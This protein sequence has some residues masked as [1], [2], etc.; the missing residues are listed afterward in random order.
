[1]V[2][3]PWSVEAARVLA[4]GDIDG[5]VLN[6]ARGFCEDS[7]DL[8]DG[9]PLRRPHVLDRL[10]V[11]LE[12]I[13]R[14]EGLEELSEPHAGVKRELGERC[15]ALVQGRRRVSLRMCMGTEASLICGGLC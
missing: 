9:W 1:M 15:R 12:P 10:I 3:G 13:G 6:Y 8:L 7:L 11:D 5:L 14:L 2:T 4:G